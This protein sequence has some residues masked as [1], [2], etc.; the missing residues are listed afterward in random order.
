MKS[1]AFQILFKHLRQEPPLGWAQLSHQKVRLLVALTGVA[2]ADILI[3]TML[4]FQSMLFEGS[5]FVHKN[6]RADLVLLSQRTEALYFGQTF[7]RRHLYQANAVEGVAS[8]KP[9]Y[10]G[11]GAWI[12]PWD[13]ESTDVMVLAFDPAHPVLDLPE[14]DQQLDKIKL[15]NVILLDRKTQPKVG[16]VAETLDQGKSVTTELSGHRIKVEGLFTLGSSIFTEGHLITSDS[17]YLRFTGPD[18]LETVNVGALILEPDADL[19]TV[20]QALDTRLPKEVKVL[21]PEEFIQIE[22]GFWASQ[23][24]GVIFN[25]GAVMGLVVGIVIVNQVLYSDV[26]DHLPEYAT[27]KAMG[28]SDRRLL[29]VVFQEA[30]ILAILGFLP[31]YGVSLGMYQLLAYLTKIPLGMRLGVTL[32]VFTA[33][34][35]MCMISAAIAMRKLQSA[36]P[37]DVF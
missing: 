20:R 13:G 7:S 4:G 3:F 9:F 26:N 8:A 33:T 1:P 35:A 5:T 12:N 32:Q 21:T 25:F 6:L 18:S 10:F 22:V 24:S 15:P 11:G 19:E 14:V 28:Y 37:A 23:P 17:N 30:A 27:L 36:D 16:P 2:F 34:V 31:G 29:M